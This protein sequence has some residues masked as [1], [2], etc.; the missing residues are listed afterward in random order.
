[1]IINKLIPVKKFLIIIIALT[2]SSLCQDSLYLTSNAAAGG[3]TNNS[4]RIRVSISGEGE[5]AILYSTSADFLNPFRSA[6]SAVRQDEDYSVIIDINGLNPSTKYFYKVL[7]ND[8]E[9]D[10]RMRSFKTFPDPQTVNNFS[11]SFGSCQQSNSLSRGFIFSEIVK[12]EP[13]FFLQLGDW[14]YPDTTDNLPFN[15]NFFSSDYDR[16]L[17]TY[18]AK[19]RMD[20]GMDT[21]LRSVPVSYVYDDHDYTNNNASAL[22]VS[23]GVPFKSPAAG[24]QFILDEIDVPPSARLNSIRGFINNMPDYKVENSSRGIYR[25][26]IY[27]NAEFYMLDLRSQRSPDFN[28]LKMNTLTGKWEF[29]R[30]AGHTMLGNS[31]SPGEGEDQFTWL[32]RN[33]LSSSAKWKFLICSVPLNRG[34]TKGI[35]VGLLLQDSL[36][37]IPGSDAS[38]YG[39]VVPMELSDKWVGFAE[40]MD[41]M[42][43]F[44]KSNEI[45]NVFVLSGDSHTSAMDDGTNAGLPEIMA[46]NL[47]IGNSRTAALF[48]SLGVNIWNKGGQGISLNEFYNS[49]GHTEVYGNDSVVFKLIDENGTLIS[50][51]TMFDQEVLSTKVTGLSARMYQDRVIVN[52][53]IINSTGLRDFDIQKSDDGLI[54]KTAGRRAGGGTEYT[55]S[56]FY[57]R[58]FSYYR[59]RIN[60]INGSYK[61]TDAVM[62]SDE[63]VPSYYLLQNF[64]NPFN[65]STRIKFSIVDDSHV[66]IDLYNM[67]GE[68]TGTILNE[69]RRRGEHE[70]LF[71]AQGLSSGIYFYRIKAGPYSEIKKMILL[72]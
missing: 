61:F 12:Y 25:K 28:S 52:W 17:R 70:I 71:N 58:G 38:V 47:D 31:N 23:Y 51:M 59:L 57:E 49:F 41:S 64:P 4:V 50:S 45:T 40:E 9:A 2:S 24:N 33:L 54:Y 46:G 7:I 44:I 8:S 20:Y 62:I 66:N 15:T 18:R 37:T 19:F 29:V 55:Y 3:V 56:D 10:N 69:F 27:G 48:A 16:V 53:S 35:E 32:K 26:F 43:A 65:I 14:T 21:L 42:L 36:V 63:T 11:F 72:K 60:S 1:M 6:E 5:A 13:D 39:I 67:L 68:K 22:T 34:Q 30:P